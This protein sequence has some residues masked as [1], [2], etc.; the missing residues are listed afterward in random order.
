MGQGL[1]GG[2]GLAG[3]LGSLPFPAGAR[4][5]TPP[6]Q[7]YPGCT[8]PGA[9]LGYVPGSSGGGAAGGSSYAVP[10]APPEPAVPDWAGVLRDVART[11]VWTT[12][13]SP[14]QAPPYRGQRDERHARAVIAPPTAPGD[15]DGATGAT[16]LAEAEEAL[17]GQDVPVLTP[18]TVGDFAEVLSYTV[19]QG[20]AFLVYSVGAWGH[21][22]LAC[23]EI[24]KWR[25]RVSSRTVVSERE[26]GLMGSIDRPVVV[27]ALARSGETVVVE[28]RNLDTHAPSLLETRVSGWLFPLL[29]PTDDD[30]FA[31][32]DPWLGP[33]D[34]G[35]FGA[36]AGV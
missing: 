19:P 33:R 14:L 18:A 29:V 32:L 11:M 10:E 26:L 30:F 36:G 22:Y 34:Q 6:E 12:H 3:L 1:G 28:A 31:L 13:P 21:D 27:Q 15:A 17:S 23:R 5:G 2:G 24:V 35:R 25:V 8:Q 4:F 9:P 7:I 20:R 16:E